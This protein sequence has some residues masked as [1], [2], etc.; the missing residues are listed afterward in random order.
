MFLALESLFRMA[1]KLCMILAAICRLDLELSLGFLSKW[2]ALA[3][4]I[5]HR[6]HPCRFRDNRSS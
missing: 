1:N 4:V 3:A 5:T 6:L 2:A